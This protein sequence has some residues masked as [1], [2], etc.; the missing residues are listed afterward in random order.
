MVRDVTAVKVLLVD[1]SEIIHAI[2]TNMFASGGHTV[3]AVTSPDALAAD[4]LDGCDVLLVDLS[5]RHSALESLIAR[6]TRE[7]PEA[8]IMLFSDKPEAILEQ[9]ALVLRAHG[10]VR[11]SAG[12]GLV[13]AVLSKIGD[14]SRS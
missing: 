3:V 8:K 1:D 7:A 9:T 10:W 12:P 14:I 11:K 2:V 4:A 6:A 5:F 13:D